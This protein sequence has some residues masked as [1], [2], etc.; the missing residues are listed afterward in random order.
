MVLTHGAVLQTPAFAVVV[1]QFGGFAGEE[2][3]FLVVLSGTH[4]GVGAGEEGDNW[5]NSVYCVVL[6]A[7]TVQSQ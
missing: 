5:S 6:P 7:Q 3:G 2:Q 4:R 1:D